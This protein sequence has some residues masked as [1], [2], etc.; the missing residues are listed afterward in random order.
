MNYSRRQLEAL[1]EPL[2][3]CVTRK[4]GGR[5]IYGG[6]GGGSSAPA[7]Q[8]QVSDLPDWAKPYAQETLEK[9][10]ALSAAPYQAYNAPRIAG[11]SPL[12]EQAQAAAGQMGPSQ[13]GQF[14]GQVA[15]AA[16]LGA[17]GTQYS[18]F[19][20]GQ[21]TA[22]RAAQYMN[23][24]VEMAME[25]QLRE[26]QRSSEMQRMADQAQA[27]RSGAFG[28]G[29]QAIVEAERQRNLGTQMGD[30]RARGYMTA[31]DQAQQQFAREQQLREQSRQYG[32]G[33]GMQGLQTALQGAGQLGALGQ[34]EFGQQKEAIGLQSQMGAQQ[35]ALRQQGLT[36]AYQDF[37]N[38]Q[39][40]PY[41]QLGFMSDMIRGLPL[42]QQS[43]KQIYEPPP[44]AIQNIGA[45]GLGAY[46]LKQLGMFADGGQVNGYA[47]GGSVT[48]EDNVKRIVDDLS[49]IQLAQAKQAAMMRGDKARFEAIAEEEATRASERK[50]FAA[51][52]NA[53]PSNVQDRM[54]GGGIVAFNG[55]GSSLVEDEFG[56]VGADGDL[57]VVPEELEQESAGSQSRYERALDL[58]LNR[59]NA[60]GSYKPTPYTQEE[61]DTMFKRNLEREQK[62]AGDAPYSAFEN[63]LAEAE[64]GRP[65]ALQ[66]A[67]GLAALK[68]A[69]AILRPGGA[70]RGIGAAGEAFAGS[71]DTALQA[72]R[73]EKRALASM[74]FN[75]ADAQRKERMG[76]V[77]SAREA[78]AD[79]V[80][81][82]QAADRAHIQRLGIEAQAA[83]RTAQA[84]KPTAQKAPS[85]AKAAEQYG[86][87][88]LAYKKDP[89]PEN[90][91]A[92]EAWKDA[93]Q[94]SKTSDIGDTR[95]AAILAGITGQRSNAELAAETA[96]NAQQIRIDTEVAAARAAAK[97]SPEYLSAKTPEEKAA[98][99]RKAADDVRA[100]YSPVPP[101]ASARPGAGAGAAPRPGPAAAAPQALPSGLNA[102]NASTLLKVDQIYETARGPARWTGTGFVPVPAR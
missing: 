75:L 95:M 6:G 66:Q 9:G 20:M 29:R 55:E 52:Y 67:K 4:E 98:V 13:L 38:E 25:P 5:I 42:G 77:K 53:L 1:G 93:V 50:G 63:Y 8:T 35:Q 73:A 17:L 74:K 87:A 34:A 85:E 60:I 10:R 86:K 19:R 71:Y 3:D 26:A 44:S 97:Y 89:T 72:D 39:N 56:F 24:F 11:F 76:M 58:A 7:T 70:M 49:D 57:R 92:M 12:Q 45:L 78:T 27:V 30:I 90:K 54:A 2:G 18:P 48:D 37:Q 23:P 32:A 43:T 82:R 51:M 80:K 79:A 21:F 68:A 62:F 16:S 28:G 65:Q 61:L 40:Y 100:E 36:Q 14:G 31:F 47:V 64:A 81:D 94:E 33:L 101:V 41:K 102:S 96:R 69:G 88:L 15:G 83:G 84:A 59:I 99:L 91:M 22:G 46:G